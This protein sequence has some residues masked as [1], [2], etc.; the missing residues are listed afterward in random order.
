MSSDAT[1]GIGVGSVIADSYEVTGLLGRGGMGAVWVAH[2]RRLPGRRVAIKVLLEGAADPQAVMRFQREAEIASRIGHPNIVDVLDF[3]TL[4]DGTP[5]QVLEYLDGESMGARLKRG[6]LPQATVFDLAR[7]IG[8]ALLAAHRAGVVHRDLKPENILLC[9]T[10][11]GG[12]LRDRV[13]VLDFGI[14]KIRGSQ[15]VQT[16]ESVLIGTPQY[17]SPEQAKGKNREV[18]SRTDIFALGAIVYEMLSG[19]AAFTGDSVVSVLLDVV[20]GTPPP[21]R[22]LV[23]E[24]PPSVVAAVE[25]ALAKH[26]V[27]RFQDVGAF[28]D[29]LTGRPLDSLGQSRTP[30]PAPVSVVR[31]LSQEEILGATQS[32]LSAVSGPPSEGPPPVTVTTTTHRVPEIAGEGAGSVPPRSRGPLLV[33][34]A[35]ALVVVM[36][37]LLL[38][39]QD[40]PGTT[41]MTGGDSAPAGVAAGEAFDGP[42]LAGG[43]SDAGAVAVAPVYHRP[44]GGEPALPAEAVEQLV[45]A[46]RLLE[47]GDASEAIRR[48]R[49]SFFVRKSNRG[50]GLL[51]RAFC[52]KGDLENARASF[53]N[54]RTG[55]PERV[56]ALRAC[57]AADI[58]LR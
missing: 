43:A 29:A 4:A 15:T 18:D 9:A 34:A 31:P 48:A 49:Q 20:Q 52:H 8:S 2:H 44:G 16:Q 23:P 41:E 14:S 54:V 30:R 36:G 7:Q 55:S 58:H 56:R 28:I 5:Y 27:E 21:L 40:N 22:T 25:R 24:L 6:P 45:E 12:V 17:M 11:E 10:D 32:S 47:Q 57:R 26:P 42:A 46:E 50:W 13:K 3:N 53:R 35:V 38:A 51:T 1:G 19:R 33:G 39:R 37:V